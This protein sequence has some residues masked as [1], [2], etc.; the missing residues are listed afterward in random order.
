MGLLGKLF[1]RITPY[2]RPF[3]LADLSI[4]FPHRSPET[5]PMWLNV[6]ISCIGPAVVIGLVCLIFIPGPTVNKRTP[7]SLIWRRKL[8]EINA[9]WMGLGLS[10]ALAY[11]ITQGLKN[12]VGKPRPDLLARCQPDT[13]NL[14]Q[15]IIES[16]ATDVARTWVKVSPDI[17]TNPD[18]K[19]VKDGF[20]SWPSGHS[21]CEI[22]H[23]IPLDKSIN[24]MNL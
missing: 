3:S 22:W 15:Y 13:A 2:K 1:D 18:A 14:E 17:C 8:W 23:V 16:F 12:L 7:K 21:S 9:G 5:V 20:R 11:F 10:I 24:R 6:V 19:K 4:S